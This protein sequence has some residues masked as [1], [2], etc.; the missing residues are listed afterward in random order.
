MKLLFQEIV[1]KAISRNASDIHFIPSEDEVHIKF[2]VN[3]YLE[4]Y[5]TFKIT[6]YQKLL[7]YMKFKAGLDVSTHQ[8]AQS[9]RYTYHSKSIYYLRISTLPLSLGSESCVIRIIPQY[10]QVKKEFKDFRDFKHLMNKKQGLIL[11]TGPTGSGKSTLMYQMVLYAYKELNLNVIT[12]ENPV[13][14]ILRGVTQ[15]SINKKAGIDYLNSFKAILRC[16]P[17]VILIGEIRDAEVAKCVIQA[18]LS[19]HLVLSTMHSNNCKGAIL[20]LME[21]GISIQE[22]S[23][24]INLISNQRLITTLNNQRKLVCELID[25]KQIQYFFEHNNTLPKS[26]N[27]LRDKLLSLSKEGTICEEIANKYI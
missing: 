10:F 12:I 17:D 8:I 7:V 19:G 11:F 2:R 15:I 6:V 20:R 25:Q 14:Q 3:D 4:L 18:S 5:E 13:E 24:S 21:M 9:G 16:D 27:N 1:N 23:Q 26:F 22:I